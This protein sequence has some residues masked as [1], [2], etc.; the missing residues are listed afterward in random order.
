MAVCSFLLQASL[1]VSSPSTILRCVCRG[2]CDRCELRCPAVLRVRNRTTAILESWNMLQ[3]CRKL[4]VHPEE[5][6]SLLAAHLEHNERCLRV[7]EV[8]ICTSSACL[9]FIFWMLNKREP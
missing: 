1:A 5:Y 7:L 3:V 2:R 4:H 8:G 9:N 6:S